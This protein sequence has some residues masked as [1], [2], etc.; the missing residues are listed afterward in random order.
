MVA[1]LVVIGNLVLKGLMK[2]GLMQGYFEITNFTKEFSEY[3]TGDYKNGE[4]IGNWIYKK[5]SKEN[6]ESIEYILYMYEDGEIVKKLD[7]D[8]EAQ[9]K[10]YEPK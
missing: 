5:I 2:D 4:R 10:L 7:L 6:T 9:L 1:R 3:W 8:T